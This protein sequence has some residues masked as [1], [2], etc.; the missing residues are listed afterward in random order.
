M[1]RV[2]LSIDDMATHLT[3]RT[4]LESEGHQVVASDPDVVIAG[5]PEQAVAAA[6][7]HPA[8]VLATAGAIRSAVQAM[9]EGVFGYIF[10]PLQPGEPG[11]MVQR[12]LQ[13]PSSPIPTQLMSLAE[14]E[15]M[16]IQHVLRQCNFNRTKAAS[17]LGV[18]R[19][20]LWRKLK[21]F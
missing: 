12:A 19:N 9:R 5:A 21:Q 16:Y 14:V 15:R 10:V 1:A 17:V 7:T 3:L 20:T 2:Q 8:L 6:R 18:G 13:Q 4:I 11:I